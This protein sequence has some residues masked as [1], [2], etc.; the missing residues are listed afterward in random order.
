MP[1]TLHPS[2]FKARVY[3]YLEPSA[4][5]DPVRP[6]LARAIDDSVLGLTESQFLTFLHDSHHRFAVI[7]APEQT[8]ES[9]RQA[10][11]AK[12]PGRSIVVQSL[13]WI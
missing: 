12:H 3:F 6:A 13:N 11:Q 10:L 2:M 4:E 5:P 1:P 7:T 9:A 8:D